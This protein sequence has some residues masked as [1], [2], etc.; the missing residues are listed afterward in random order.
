MLPPRADTSALPEP[1]ECHQEFWKAHW[2]FPDPMAT[3]VVNERDHI[4]ESSGM[5]QQTN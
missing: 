2:E 5:K 4:S 1:L 3:L